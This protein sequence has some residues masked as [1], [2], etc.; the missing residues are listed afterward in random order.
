MASAHASLPEYFGG[1][2]STLGLS[3][4]CNFNSEDPANTY[5]CPA[6]LAKSQGNAFSFNTISVHQAFTP[7]EDVVVANPL[8]DPTASTEYGDVDINDSDSHFVGLHLSMLLLPKWQAKLSASIFSP[9]DKFIDA[10]TGDFYLP[11][12]VMYKSRYKRT[13][14]F[15]AISLPFN[16]KLYY[17]VGLLGG[18]QSSGHTN[19][20]ASESGST[21][22][23]SGSMKFNASPSLAP[24]FSLYYEFNNHHASYLS[25]HSE[26]QSNFE[27]IADGYTPIGSSSVKYDWK[28]S[29]MMFYDPATFRL[30]HQ[31]HID[32]HAFIGTVEYQLWKNYETPKM[33]IKNQGGVLISSRDYEDVSMNN[34]F[35]YKLGYQLQNEK[36]MWQIGYAFRPT[37]L[38]KDHSEAGNSL[39]S[40]EHIVSSSYERAVNF[41]DQ[42]FNLALG[43]QLHQLETVKVDKSSGIE[44]GDAG[45]KIGDGGYEIGGQ[46]F[47]LS[48]GLSWV[49]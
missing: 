3:N 6:L 16:E 5:Y 44:N 35:I 24:T 40:N 17:S 28:L 47:V 15:A 43:L 33:N 45:R 39:D 12:Y 25:Y 21:E 31:Y 7:I 9:T 37:P 2:V 46:V 20:V 42:K 1:S 49:L 27:H 18:L 26:M 38:E 36:S 13:Q 19:I 34:I 30:G 11:E 22:P 32:R 48:L 4:Q 41:L 29:S 8:N 23:S 14:F 10:G